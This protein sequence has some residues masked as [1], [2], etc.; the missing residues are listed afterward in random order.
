MKTIALRFSNKF[1][2]DC[3]TIEA[4][5]ELI[6]KNGYVWYGKLGNRIAASVFDEILGN[7]EPRILLIH[8]GAANRYWAYVDKIQHDI[9]E[10][11]DIPEYYRDDADKF[12][13][14]FR[15]IKFEDAPRDIMS[16]CT[17]TSS[18]QELGIASKHSMSPYFKIIAPDPGDKR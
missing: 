4:H 1:A 5:N 14:W 2:P 10:R 6:Q 15:V 13:T 12:R 11:D 18:G 17:M 9:P 8:S 16:K 3:G 7:D